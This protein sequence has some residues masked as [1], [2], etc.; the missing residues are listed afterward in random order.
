MVERF[1]D[2]REDAKSCRKDNGDA[3]MA[4][5]EAAHP[6][7]DVAI[8]VASM[9]RC[10]IARARRVLAVAEALAWSGM[11][12]RPLSED[13]PRQH[14]SEDVC[15]DSSRDSVQDSRQDAARCAD[16]DSAQD[17]AQDAAQ[18]VGES[19]SRQTYGDGVGP[20]GAA[21]CRRLREP[22]LAESR[23]RQGRKRRAK[24]CAR[25]V[26]RFLAARDAGLLRHGKLGEDAEADISID[27][28]QQCVHGKAALHGRHPPLSEGRPRL[29]AS[30]PRISLGD[31]ECDLALGGGLS[32]GALHEISGVIFADEPSAGPLRL[33]DAR[34]V[35]ARPL[36]GHQTDADGD[37][38]GGID[39]GADEWIVP[40][41]C[42]LHVVRRAVAHPS[43]AGRSIAWIGSRV[44]PPRHMLHVLRHG[45]GAASDAAGRA[46]SGAVQPFLDGALGHRSVFIGDA[47]KGAVGGDRL[48]G[49]ASDR[50]ASP[51]RG[52]PTSRSDGQ[53]RVRLW[54][55]ELAIRMDAAGVIVV[56]GRGFDHLAWRRLQLAATAAHQGAWE[57]VERDGGLS[58]CGPL[59]LVVTPPACEATGDGA[60][61]G[62][63]HVARHADRRLRTAATRWS[64]SAERA[65][66]PMHVRDHGA[67]RRHDAPF[68]FQWRMHLTHL[69]SGHGGQVGMGGAGGAG[70]EHDTDHESSLVHAAEVAVGREHAHLRHA[71]FHR[72]P[73]RCEGVRGDSVSV[74][75]AIANRALSV[76]VDLP[77]TLCADESWRALGERTSDSRVRRLH[78]EGQDP[79][80]HKL[81]E[82]CIETHLM[83]GEEAEAPFSP[84]LPGIHHG[85]RGVR[86]A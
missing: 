54:C 9:D 6:E 62:R 68:Q 70:S 22:S 2:F 19:A 78:G 11:G 30:A 39:G 74:H 34:F 83:L 51:L 12:V 57:R 8:S 86:S 16:Q 49:E 47:P 17:A 52:K 18:E 75:A 24:Q 61:D 3:G 71:P 37:A 10:R 4:A 7:S 60:T 67:R 44:H 82:P 15:E 42:L 13:F 76:S 28:T 31:E 14:P 33:T 50:H 43:L 77:R 80:P 53:A 25:D 73:P 48:A 20:S 81:Q 56:D 26:K 79:S 36:G 40:F 29:T 59:V 5:G 41:G 55:A 21:V 66:D 38:D 35:D 23:P 65:S 58:S 69:R 84:P 46:W 85:G 32:C 63:S 45:Q 1:S 72:S 64:V 27:E